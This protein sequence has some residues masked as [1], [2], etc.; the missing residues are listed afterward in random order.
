MANMKEI[1]SEF[2]TP[3]LAED[4]DIQNIVHDILGTIDPLK[5]SELIDRAVSPYLND[6][7]V[8]I[9]FLR[10]K[11]WLASLTGIH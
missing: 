9:L 8:K 3:Y 10:I 11:N 5:I 6:D 4:I 2:I 1:F 7:I